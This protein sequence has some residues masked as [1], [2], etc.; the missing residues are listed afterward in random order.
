[1]C[2]IWKKEK[3]VEMNS[4]EIEKVFKKVNNI[5]V[6]RLTGGEPFL[7]E[8]LVDI[9]NIIAKNTS[10]QILHITTNGIL[11]DEIIYFIKNATHQAIHLKISLNA[12]MDNHDKIIGFKG[13]YQ[14]AIETIEALKGIQDKYKFSLAINQTITDWA[15]CLDSKKIRSV[16]A[17]YGLSYLPVIA[18][19]N[20]PLYQLD[21]EREHPKTEFLPYT[22]F[23]K[24]DLETM[25]RDLL[26]EADKIDNFIERLVKKYY[27]SGLYH[28][29]ISG[30][31]YPRAK[32]VALKKHIRILPN[33][34]VPTCLYNAMVAGNILEDDFSNLWNG[35]KIEKLRHWVGQCEG[36]WV[37]CEAIPNAV[38]SN[39]TMAYAVRSLYE[40][41]K[42]KL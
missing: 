28:R 2:D 16:C 24:N 39:N 10:A 31:K 1:M 20:A 8:D 35:R 18:F 40:G 25:L 19:K 33:G 5:R 21:A 11:K 9:A 4:H 36:C 17:K 22:D 27:L 34:D 14:K 26:G 7:R 12:Y 32:C 30:K 15:S 38:Y 37:E 29:L 6:I 13:A 3:S 42:N 41:F 23:R